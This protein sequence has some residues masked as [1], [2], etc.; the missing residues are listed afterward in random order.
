MRLHFYSLTAQISKL[1]SKTAHSAIQKYRVGTHQGLQ[2]DYNIV[3]S[4]YVTIAVV[5]L[6]T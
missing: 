3:H 5:S 4:S 2:F 6:Q 1:K